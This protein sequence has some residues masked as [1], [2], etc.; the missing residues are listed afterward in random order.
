M[1]AGA[2]DTKLGVLL[3]KLATIVCAP[4]VN[5]LV[6]KIASPSPLTVV[7]A[8][9][10]SLSK[11]VTVP[12][13]P[14][15]LGS[16]LTV[17]VNV[18]GW[19]SVDGLSLDVKA[20]VVGAGLT[21]TPIRMLLVPSDGDPRNAA[22]IWCVPTA[23]LLATSVAAPSS[24]TGTTPRSWPDARSS[25]LTTPSGVVPAGHWPCGVTV[26]VNVTA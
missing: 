13:V 8:A 2:L 16:A 12:W 21:I 19:P 18:T 20:S 4:A 3:A 15:A 23:R 11:N 14:T 10:V 17:A 25:K 6:V 26:A 1:E 5:A 24:P 22:R 9:A 7:V